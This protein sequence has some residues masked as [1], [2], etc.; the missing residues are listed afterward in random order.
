MK[1]NITERIVYLA[2][3]FDVFECSGDES[4]LSNKLSKLAEEGY[5]V[6]TI[7]YNENIIA[8]LSTKVNEKR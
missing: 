5:E 8:L 2:E 4:D 6:Q 7:H 3:M 1:S